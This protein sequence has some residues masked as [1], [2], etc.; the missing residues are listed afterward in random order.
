ML[1]LT[2]KLEYSLIALSHMNKKVDS[3][4]CTAKEIAIQYSI[5]QE[6]LAKTLQLLAKLNFINAVKGPNGG[7]EVNESL[8][9]VNFMDFIEKIEGPQG[10]V[11]CN[12]EA[13]CDLIEYC[14]I[15]KPIRVIN[16]NLKNMFSNISLSEIT[17]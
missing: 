17:Q 15:R 13:D 16:D 6:A 12:I 2:R 1:K 3:K 8:D 11:D 14:N 9:N 10:L 7:Y 4:L 5:P